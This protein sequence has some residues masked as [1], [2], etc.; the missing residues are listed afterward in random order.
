MKLSTVYLCVNDMETSLNFYRLLLQKEPLYC[1][2]DRWAAFDCGGQLA[3]YNRKYDEKLLKEAS[4]LP[5]NQAYREDFFKE[6]PEKK[7]TIVV[8]NFET[9]DLKSE[10]GRIKSLGIGPVS[11]IMYV[12]VHMPYY[13]FNVMDPE[14]NVL[15]ITGRYE[16]EDFVPA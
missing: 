14:R 15:E 13:Y 9:E 5:F 4:D 2:D 1:N 6:D 10:Y 16:M 7:N 11:E 12:N 8:F 3:L